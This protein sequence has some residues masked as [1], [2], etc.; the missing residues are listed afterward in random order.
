VRGTTPQQDWLVR[1]AWLEATP[2]LIA[3]P[4]AAVPFT[5]SELSAARA[6][7]QFQ[8]WQHRAVQRRSE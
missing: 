4:G 2:Q 1:N 7:D 6:T 3:L 5:L 8:T